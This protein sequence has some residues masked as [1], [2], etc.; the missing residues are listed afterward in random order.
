MR[1]K[2]EKATF[3][4]AVTH[5]VGTLSISA[6]PALLLQFPYSAGQVEQTRD[7][8]IYILQH[9]L[10]LPEESYIVTCAFDVDATS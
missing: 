5:S 1:T 10:R 3:A 2:T 6:M 8:C 4:Q 9:S 7:F